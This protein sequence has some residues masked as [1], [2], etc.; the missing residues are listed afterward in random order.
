LLHLLQVALQTAVFH[1]AIE[2]M[3]QAPSANRQNPGPRLSLHVSSHRL[4]VLVGGLVVVVT[5]GVEV[6]L[7]LVEDILALVV[8]ASVVVAAPPC[9]QEFPMQIS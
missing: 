5:R 3:F 9:A 2:Q 6:D 4:F 1:H 8:V 7:M